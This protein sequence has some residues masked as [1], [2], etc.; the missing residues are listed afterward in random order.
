MNRF[1]PYANSSRGFGSIFSGGG[2]GNQGSG[3]WQKSS[4][5]KQETKKCATHGKNRTL[6]NLEKNEDEE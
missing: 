5:P 6:K 1:N 2:Y 4:G 3:R